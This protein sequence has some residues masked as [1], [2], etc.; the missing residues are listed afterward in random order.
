MWL[1]NIHVLGG[2]Q[3]I[4]SPT[5]AAILEHPDTYTFHPEF[6]SEESVAY[7]MISRDIAE[8]I[9]RVLANCGIDAEVIEKRMPG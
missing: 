2:G 7:K 1:S 3:R 9:V 4:D 8:R 6:L 5:W